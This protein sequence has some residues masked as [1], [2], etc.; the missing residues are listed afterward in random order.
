[1]LLFED[2][3]ATALKALEVGYTKQIERVEL[4]IDLCKQYNGGNWNGNRFL[5]REIGNSITSAD[6]YGARLSMDLEQFNKCHQSHLKR[7]PDFILD[8]AALI[9]QQSQ[10]AEL[11]TSLARLRKIWLV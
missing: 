5:P 9:H 11:L 1:M 3:L 8:T 10:L 6:V 2:M 7:H 4:A